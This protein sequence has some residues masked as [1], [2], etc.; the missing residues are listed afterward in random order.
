ML[1]GVGVMPTPRIHTGVAAGLEAPAPGTAAAY[2]EADPED[3]D[4]P[5]FIRKRG[6]NV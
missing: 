1:S 2:A 3:L 4:V 6:Q 5:A